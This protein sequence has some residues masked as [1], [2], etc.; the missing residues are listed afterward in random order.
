MTFDL[1][2]SSQ[3]NMTYLF[4]K[5]VDKEGDKIIVIED[6]EQV[7]TFVIL[8]YLTDDE[9]KL[10]IDASGLTEDQYKSY[11][12]TLALSEETVAVVYPKTQTFTINVFKGIEEI[13]NITNSTNSTNSTEELDEELQIEEETEDQ[14]EEQK[15]KIRR[16]RVN[17]QRAQNMN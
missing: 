12:F 2:M 7:R 8:E 10:S 15:E 4:P 16:K 6:L 14:N 9:L 1:N 17:L 13:A 5:I 11:T 3:T